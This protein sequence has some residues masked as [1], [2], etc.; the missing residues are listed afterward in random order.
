MSGMASLQEEQV[1]QLLRCNCTRCRRRV[2]E[3][4]RPQLNWR[5]QVQGAI[6][7]ALKELY[8]SPGTERTPWRIL[9]SLQRHW[10]TDCR[11]FPDPNTYVMVWV[12]V[13][14]HFMKHLATDPIQ[15]PPILLMEPLSMSMKAL[16]VTWSMQ[17]Q[18]AHRYDGKLTI[19]RYLVDENPAVIDFHRCL[20]AL[21]AKRLW[22]DME[23]ELEI[24]PLINGNGRRFDL[25]KEPTHRL[26]DYFMLVHDCLSEPACRMSC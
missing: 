16:G 18:L 7:G 12:K 9:Q 20:T 14:D 15:E 17:V 6:N 23:V 25:L 26:E 10:P 4:K 8:G 11:L 2:L 19:R 5:R 13:T 1:E 22:S 21:F 24:I 3:G